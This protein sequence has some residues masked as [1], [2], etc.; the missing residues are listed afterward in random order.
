MIPTNEKTVVLEVT[1]SKRRPAQLLI[2][3][4]LES[5]LRSATL[6]RGR[7]TASRAWFR[8]ELH[9]TILAMNAALRRNRRDGFR[10]ARSAS[11]LT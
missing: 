8:L 6:L 9:G 1:C 10:L 5:G 2:N 11:P 7:V 3:R 4:L